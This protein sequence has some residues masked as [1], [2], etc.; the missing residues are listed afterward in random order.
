MRVPAEASVNAEFADSVLT[1]KGRRRLIKAGG[2]ISLCH[3]LRE[4]SDHRA[5]DTPKGDRSGRH[6]HKTVKAAGSAKAKL[7]LNGSEVIVHVVV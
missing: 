4:T 3:R 6:R 7:G 5:G 1:V 2:R